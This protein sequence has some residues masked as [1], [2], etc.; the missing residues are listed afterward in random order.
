MQELQV[1]EEYLDTVVDWLEEWG[2][3]ESSLVIS[4]FLTDY[5]IG[6]KYFKQFLEISPKVLNAFEVAT[7]RLHVRWLHFALSQKD[8]PRHLHSVLMRYLRA[9]DHHV[10]DLDLAAR[11][12][13]NQ[14]PNVT[15]RR[16]ESKDYGSA[17]LQGIYKQMYD[18]NVNKRRS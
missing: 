4:Q 14:E 12:Q 10:Y 18:A 9:Y 6:W 7:S 17:E 11:Q 16:Y 5:G 13:L 3:K 15:F 8:L 1:S 2:S